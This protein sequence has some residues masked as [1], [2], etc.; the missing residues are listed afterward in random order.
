[1]YF[2]SKLVNVLFVF[3]FMVLGEDEKQ[4]GKEC[5]LKSSHR[6]PVKDGEV[7]HE[8]KGKRI[9]IFKYTGSRVYWRL[10]VPRTT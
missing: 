7:I 6:L 5:L 9:T 10:L 3:H 2:P 1:M 8:S 4:V